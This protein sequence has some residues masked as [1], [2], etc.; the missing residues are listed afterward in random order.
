MDDPALDRHLSQTEDYMPDTS[1][2]SLILNSFDKFPEAV[3]DW[4]KTHP[5]WKPIS[6]EARYYQKQKTLVVI[7]EFEYA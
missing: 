6:V 2:D 1:T 4:I 5:S 3:D 7:I